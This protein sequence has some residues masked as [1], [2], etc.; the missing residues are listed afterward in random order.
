M[1]I[2]FTNSYLETDNNSIILEGYNLSHR[3]NPLIN[4]TFKVDALSQYFDRV[5]G[6]NIDRAELSLHVAKNNTPSTKDI[7]EKIK[8]AE[9]ELKEK[10]AEKLA[11]SEER[12]KNKITKEYEDSIRSMSQKIEYVD[13]KDQKIFELQKQ[14]TEANLK[15]SDDRTQEM[16][17]VREKVEKEFELRINLIK[18][19]SQ[20][21]IKNLKTQIEKLEKAHEVKI[22]EQIDDTMNGTTETVVVSAKKRKKA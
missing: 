19:Q 22:D 8:N 7:D 1:L 16:T 3:L 18:T 20:Q 13:Q 21:E 6:R 2:K 10:Y 12:L 17:K 14:L 11:L 9:K 5:S 15:L 4:H